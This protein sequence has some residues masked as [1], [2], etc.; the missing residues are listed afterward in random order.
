MQFIEISWLLLIDENYQDAIKI[1]FEKSLL[2]TEPPIPKIKNSFL[3]D[4]QVM[5]NCCLAI[6]FL[7]L[8]N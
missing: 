6:C 1:K 7:Y 4:I 3:E 5:Q 8:H 2:Y